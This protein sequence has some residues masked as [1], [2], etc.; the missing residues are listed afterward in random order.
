MPVRARV[1]PGPKPNGYILKSTDIRPQPRALSSLCIIAFMASGDTKE[2]IRYV[3]SRSRTEDISHRLLRRALIILHS[4]DPLCSSSR[5]HP[6]V[7]PD[8]HR[9]CFHSRPESAAFTSGRRESRARQGHTQRAPCGATWQARPRSPSRPPSRV[10]PATQ[11]MRA[12]A[13]PAARPAPASTARQEHSKSFNHQ[14]FLR[15]SR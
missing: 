2:W 6:S 12:A 13:A 1:L 10:P 15:I 11:R 8:F 9:D 4:S 7:T 5:F 3:A 14:P